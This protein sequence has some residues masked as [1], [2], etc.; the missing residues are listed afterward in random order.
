VGI[1][2]RR[3]LLVRHD[4]ISIL[5]VPATDPVLPQVRDL[6]YATL[7]RPFGVTRND[8]W[9]E[10]DPASTHIVALDGDRLAGYVRL[11][12]EGGAGHVR[13]VSVVPEYRSRGVASDLV[14]CAVA[15]ARELGLPLAFLNA[16][17]RAVGLYERVGFRVTE[18][19]FR[20][21][22]TYLPHVRMEMPLR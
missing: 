5:Q 4:G 1:D 14:V 15:R 12:V 3:P 20:M 17:Q 8:A 7:H 22:R 18:G 16:R 11:I 9:N 2:S 6:C 10:A 19:P 21:G 13:Q